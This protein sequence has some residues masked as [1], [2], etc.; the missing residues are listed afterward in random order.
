MIEKIANEISAEPLI[1]KYLYKYTWLSGC[2]TKVSPITIW[3]N[4]G[5]IVFQIDI[6]KN[7][8]NKFIERM[9]KKYNLRYG[10]FEKSDGSC[11]SSIHLYMKEV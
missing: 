7:V 9:V 11:P 4:R 2:S 1:K 3:K 10:Y 6:D 8:F 5:E